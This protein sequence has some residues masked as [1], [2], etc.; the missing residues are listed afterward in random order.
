MRVL[1]VSQYFYPENFNI[2]HIASDLVRMGH[3]VTVLTGMPNYPSGR[4]AKGYGGWRISRETYR[5]VSVVRVPMI[6]RGRGT[7]FDLILNYLSYAVMASLLGPWV[8]RDRPDVV[9]VYQ[10]S[11]L[12]V[13]LPALV[14]SFFRRAPIVF[15]IQDLWPETLVAL[16]VLKSKGLVNLVRQMART[17]YRRCSMILVQ[18]PV[19]ETHIRPLCRSETE[20]RYLPQI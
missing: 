17:I 20:I 19:L 16:N 1:V 2:N 4:F 10:V 11:P 15:W 14:M 5:G 12:T 13:G 7:A 18:S 8:M 3:D 6:R 9:F